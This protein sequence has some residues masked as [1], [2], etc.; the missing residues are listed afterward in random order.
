MNAQRDELEDY[1][2]NMQ[3]AWEGGLDIT[4]EMKECDLMQR[5]FHF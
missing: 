2:T 5:E 3:N 1:G 4:K